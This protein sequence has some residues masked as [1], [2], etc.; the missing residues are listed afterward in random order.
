MGKYDREVIR[1]QMEREIREI[2]NIS[3]KSGNT[4][5]FHQIEP[6]E[7]QIYRHIEIHHNRL[8]KKKEVLTLSKR[9]R[10]RSKEKRTFSQWYELDNSITIILVIDAV[11]IDFVLH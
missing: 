6:T 10:K 9:R 11:D 1:L 4:E 8:C 5:V 2:S 3:P 7:H